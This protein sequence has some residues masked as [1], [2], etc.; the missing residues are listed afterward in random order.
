MVRWFRPNGER[1]KFGDNVNF[2]FE[3][4]DLQ[5]ASPATISRMGVIFL[6]EEDVDVEVGWNFTLVEFIH[7]LQSLRRY[8][9]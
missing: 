3:S 8:I 4:H 7:S 2:V 1:I 9:E 5:H 6:S